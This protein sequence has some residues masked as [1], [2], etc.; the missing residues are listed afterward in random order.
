MKL[1][2]IALTT[3]SVLALAA[4]AVF[5][6]DLT[7][8]KS[9]RNRLVA[10]LKPTEEVPLNSSVAK[11]SFKATI[12]EDNQTIT[13]ELS[14]EGLEATPTQANIHVGQRNVNGGVSVFLCGNPPAVPPAIFPQPQPCPPAPATIT[15]ELTAANIVGPAG[16]GIAPSVGG[17]NE[18]AEL[19]A[20]LRNG[21][22]Y[23]NVHT[24][25]FP[26]GEVRGQVFSL[27]GGNN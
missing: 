21:D 17:V 26:G 13:F 11:A 24:T 4:G 23:A 2:H 15:G 3:T 12:D 25:K 9:L 16:Q 5:A 1:S 14:Y 19:V 20:L 27:F 6:H 22:T 8:L 10:V 7:D 18:F